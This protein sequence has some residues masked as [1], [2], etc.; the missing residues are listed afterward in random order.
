MRNDPCCSS[1]TLPTQK[2]KQM[3][4]FHLKAETEKY[5]LA[6]WRPSFTLCCRDAEKEI[7]DMKAEKSSV[8]SLFVSLISPTWFCEAQITV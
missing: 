2:K 8:W 7:T 5:L 3:L 1:L 6:L 4:Y